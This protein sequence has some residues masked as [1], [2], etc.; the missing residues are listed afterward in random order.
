MRALEANTVAALQE[1]RLRRRNLI[2]MQPKDRST[3]VSEDFGF[4]NGPITVSVSVYDAIL[5]N[6]FTRV[7]HGAGG[8]ISVGQIPLHSSIE[9]IEISIEISQIEDDVA[10]AIRGYDPRGCPIQIYRGMYD[11]DA[12]SFVDPPYTRFAG[13]VDEAP[14]RTPEV[15]GRGSI[16]LKCAS[17]TRDLLRTNTDVSSHASQLLR[18]AGADKFNQYAVVAGEWD[19]WWGKEKSKGSGQGFGGGEGGNGL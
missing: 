9:V 16:T 8:L 5:Q 11:P 4:W 10:E 15:G 17:A 3:G 19:I 14:I 12:Q 13:Y 2:F 6:N 7:F 1:R 18:T